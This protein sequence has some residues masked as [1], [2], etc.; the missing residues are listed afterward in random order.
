LKVLKTEKRFLPFW[1]SIW[2]NR[3][4]TT[5]RGEGIKAGMRGFKINAANFTA[6]V[7]ASVFGLTGAFI[8]YANVAA[9]AN[10]TDGQAASWMMSGTVLGCIATILLCLY[11]RQPIV[12]MPSLPALLIMAPLF[13]RYSLGEM[14]AGYV[15]AALVIFLFGTFRIIG[16]IAQ[17]FPVPIIMGM[18]AGVF[19]SYALQMVDGVRNQPVAGGIIIG[20]FLVAHI[21][22]KKV[23][24]LLAAL[25]AGVIATFVFEPTPIDTSL[26]R[27]YP[28]L[29]VSPAFN[30]SIVFSVTIPLVLL[31][32]ADTLKGFGVL[33]A[34]DYEPPLNTNMQ[35]AGLVSLVA[36][37]FLSHPVSMAGPVT[38]IVG[39]RAAGDTRYRYV[40]SVLNAVVMLLAGIFAGFVLPFVKNL[41]SDIGH[42]IA[43]LAMLGLFTSSMELAFGSKKH[44]KGAFTAFIVGMSGF[45]LWGISAPVWAIAF[46]SI[47][48]FLTERKECS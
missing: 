21:L 32:L 43:G 47:V 26:F 8:L 22:P 1:K 46:G 36:A 40:A 18:I 15:L 23:P 35:V 9:A 20:A 25:F 44:V 17:V 45:S 6:F 31:V 33:K 48:S 12:I 10:M 39:S 38:A 41:P 29:F 37:F 11:Y 3:K 34:N 16:K 14:V 28:P 4:R 13:S 30:Q 27:F 24:P 19:M 2:V 42:I 7:T 5:E